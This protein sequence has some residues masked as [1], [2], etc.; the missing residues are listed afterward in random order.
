MPAEKYT[1]ID[2][3]TAGEP[4]R[5]VTDLPVALEGLDVPSKRVF[6]MNSPQ[7]E[8]IRQILCFEPRGHAD[9][10]GGFVTE[11]NDDGAHFG[12]LF[13]HKDGFSTA[14][15]HGTI[16]LGIWAL[17]HG[18]VPPDPSGVT[19]VVIDMPS[20]RVISRVHADAHGAVTHADF[21]N[22]ASYVI[23]KDVAVQTA[24]G[25]VTVDVSFGGA[26]YAQLDAA[27]VGLSVTPENYGEIIAIGREI[28]WALN[29]SFHAQHP[30][31]ARLSGIYGTI[32]FE[33]LST[34]GEVIQR[35]ATVF[36]D[37]EV[38]RSPC[39]SGTS[40]RVATLTDRG[41]LA[42]GQLLQHGSIVGSQFQAVVLEHRQ[43]DGYSAVIPQVTG[44]AYQTGEHTFIVDPRDE[45][46]PGFVLR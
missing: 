23:S 37:G 9:M 35:N 5:I 46:T 41:I 45:L 43:V 3:H 25:E 33:D 8:R 2:Y 13:W 29:D 12:V 36:A 14:C 38:D 4:F 26:I 6:A 31:D 22:V 39:G 7:V 34:G 44:A 32:V 10:Y 21:I 15:G 18:I 27:S 20:G 42:A 1:S 19:D 16:A 17:E 11:P 30:V 40:A 24:R 28:K